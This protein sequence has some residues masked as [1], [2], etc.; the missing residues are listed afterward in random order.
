MGKREIELRDAM[1]AA[2][3]AARVTGG[4]FRALVPVYGSRMGV[5]LQVMRGREIRQRRRAVTLTAI[6]ATIVGAAAAV[7]VERVIAHRES[8]E[9]VTEQ[10]AEAI[11]NV[12][13]EAAFTDKE[14]F[15]TK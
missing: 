7:A 13:A 1:A 11:E 12:K 10:A 5:A 6:A 15:T 9:P 14:A 2:W 3:A 8:A 4:Q